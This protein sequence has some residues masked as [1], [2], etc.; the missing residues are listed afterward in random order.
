MEKAVI[1]TV[2]IVL[3]SFITK[4][5]AVNSFP[6]ILPGLATEKVAKI[7][8][9]GEHNVLRKLRPPERWP[10]DFDMTCVYRLTAPTKLIRQQGFI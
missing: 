8:H 7:F 9:C 2:S 10:L 4:P 5:D 6:R 3:K 1:F